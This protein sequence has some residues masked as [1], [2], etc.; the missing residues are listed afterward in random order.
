MAQQAN[1]S[2][3]ARM[4]GALLHY[5]A[6]V[7]LSAI[8]LTPMWV[9]VSTSM[10]NEVLI[11]DK[12]PVWFFFVPTIEHYQ[13]VIGSAG[14]GRYL[15][16]STVVGLVSTF[17]TLAFGGMA[18]YALARMD[19]RG[20]MGTCQHHLAVAHGAPGRAGSASVFDCPCA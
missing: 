19:F 14:F 15:Y 5:S 18:A 13:Y 7:V 17:L 20:R 12:E 10:K 11:F 1:I 2:P 9:M 16:N 4:R 6:L 8:I 3:A